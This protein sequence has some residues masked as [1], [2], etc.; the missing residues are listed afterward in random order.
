MSQIENAF[1]VE[2]QE[3]NQNILDELTR[4]LN[5]RLV[6]MGEVTN[7]DPREV[8]TLD[9]IREKIGKDF[10]YDDLSSKIP[11]DL[12]K[13][14]VQTMLS[15]EQDRLIENLA[16]IG[17]SEVE[18]PFMARYRQAK[19]LGLD[20]DVDPNVNYVLGLSSEVN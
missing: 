16:E 14:Y 8:S 4:E 19:A 20:I 12:L 17:S 1:L 5:Y 3:E 9:K 10:S 18:R 13:E 15:V 11:E 6:D 2:E 7:L